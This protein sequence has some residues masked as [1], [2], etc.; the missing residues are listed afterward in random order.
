ML[1]HMATG[2]IFDERFLEHDTGPSHP[3]RPQ[4]LAAI[5]DALIERGLWDRLTPL[6]FTPAGD[7]S[8]LRIHTQGYIDRLT[9]ACEHS[10]RFIDSAD[11]A[12]CP[13][14]EAIARLAAGGL[15]AA[16]DAVMAGD[17]RNALCLVRPPGHHAERD[18]SMGFCLYNNVAVA[19]EHWVHAHGLKRVAIV[20]F[21]VHHGNGTQHSF[22]ERADV[23]FISLHQS[24]RTL[25]PGTGFEHEQGI[26]DGTGYTLN[27][28]MLPGG[29]DQAYREAFTEKVLPK[30]DA[31]QPQ[32]MLVSAGFDAADADPLANMRVTPAGF[33]W[34]AEE[35][36]AVA[37]KHCDRRFVAT[38][39]G[40][41]DLGR[42]GEGVAG[43]AEAMLD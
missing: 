20:D 25:Y 2:L 23:L 42:L 12:I 33:K 10:R 13:E 43:L 38:L 24:P 27:V 39:E 17:V 15:I 29:D 32:A 5:R 35:L 22:D 34:M 7:E 18:R 28:P 40:G 16:V 30:L 14:S 9:D 26:G 37:E 11:S 6:A 3:E 36:L 41:Y 21:D 8:L 31:Y 1:G 4:R 19:A